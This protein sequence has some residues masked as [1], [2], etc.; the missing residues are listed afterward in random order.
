MKDLWKK[1]KDVNERLHGLRD[2]SSASVIVS[3]ISAIF[4]IYLAVPLGTEHYGEVSYFIA[5]SSIVSTIALLGI[6]NSIIIYTAK[7]VKIQSTLY[8][9]SIISGIVASVVLFFIFYDIGVSLYVIG[10]II[11]SLVIGEML[12]RKMYK[13][14]SKYIIIQRI[15]LVVF[16][17]GLYYIIGVQGIILGF[18]ISYFPF[19]HKIYK[20]FKNSKINFSLIKPRLG[21]IMNNYALELTRIASYSTD[22]LIIYP[23]FGFSFLGNYQLGIQFLNMMVLLPTVVY[24]YI[25]PQDA[26]GNSNTNLKKATILASVIISGAG[27]LL[28]PIII[29]ELFPKFKE[30]VEI[31]QIMSLAAIP[32]TV[33]FMYISK[34]L[35]MEKSNII[36]IGSGI[37]LI[38][39][40][41]SII[42]LGK[43]YHINGVAVSPV[44]AASS[45][46]IYL[47]T[48]TRFVKKFN[49]DVKK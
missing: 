17:I 25:L 4:W 24:Q 34:F 7:E 12:G 23:L 27:I 18:A 22:K 32:L 21:F 41:S 38:I 31:I 10:S 36:F 46:C 1:I 40:I 2:L 11:F 35:S 16:A 8:L 6:S 48:M 33:N 14:Y 39:L 45:E 47:S 20:E 28:S 42:F 49:D 26:S 37:Y 43:L 19:S 3:G 9:I 30:A 15:L 13:E 29:P 5:I 44:L